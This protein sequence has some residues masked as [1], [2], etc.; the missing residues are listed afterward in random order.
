MYEEDLLD[1]CWENLL[2]IR[3]AENKMEIYQPKEILEP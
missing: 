3:G 2:K 1:Q